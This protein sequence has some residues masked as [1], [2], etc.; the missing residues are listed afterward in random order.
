MTLLN[1]GDLIGKYKV[2]QVLGNGSFGVVY[3]AWDEDA[4]RHVA[5]KVAHSDRMAQLRDGEQAFHT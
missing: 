3:L 5:V 1:K 4:Q 2:V